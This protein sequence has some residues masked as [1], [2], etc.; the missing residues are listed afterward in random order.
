MMEVLRLKTQIKY[1]SE[2]EKT[3]SVFLVQL[4][5]VGVVHGTTF[6]SP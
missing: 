6:F 3:Q 4:Q 2:N 1:F 5:R